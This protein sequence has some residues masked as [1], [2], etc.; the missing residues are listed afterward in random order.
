MQQQ[1]WGGTGWFPAAVVHCSRRR[2]ALRIACAQGGSCYSGGEP[3]AS[4]A[5]MTYS[6]LSYRSLV[7]HDIDLA[8]WG[9]DNACSVQHFVHSKWKEG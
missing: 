3:K 5:A 7:K 9:L 4:P 8:R 6:R 1:I 2:G